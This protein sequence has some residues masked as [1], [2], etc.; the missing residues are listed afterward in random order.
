[1][2]LAPTC[3]AENKPRG[4]TPCSN[5]AVPTISGH[6]LRQS[7]GPNENLASLRRSSRTPTPSPGLPDAERT[8]SF[9]RRF[10]IPPRPEP[11][12]RATTPYPPSRKAHWKLFRPNRPHCAGFP[13]TGAPSERGAARPTSIVYKPRGNSGYPEPEVV[14]AF[15]GGGVGGGSAGPLATGPS[16]STAEPPSERRRENRR[17]ARPPSSATEETGPRRA[18]ARRRPASGADTGPPK[19]PRLGFWRSGRA[20]SSRFPRR[21]RG[22]AG[23]PFSGGHFVVWASF[24][25][26][27]FEVCPFC[28]FSSAVSKNPWSTKRGCSSPD[29]EFKAVLGWARHFV[30]GPRPRGC[31]LRRR[32]SRTRGLAQPPRPGRDR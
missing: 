13:R 9:T 1:M 24:I 2:T 15:P 27:K 18:T 3:R 17:P 4:P 28:G 26:G 7:A 12:S 21:R 14:H 8:K 23:P 20:S 31:V 10:A 29:R 6:V 5:I 32:G 19:Q 30:S 22:P 25:P 11:V 16:S